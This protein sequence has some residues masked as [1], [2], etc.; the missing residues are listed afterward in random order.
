MKEIYGIYE[1]IRIMDKQKKQAIW[2]ATFAAAFVADV[3]GL[4]R[5]SWQMGKGKARADLAN[6]HDYGCAESAVAIADAAIKGI[7][8]I[9]AEDEEFDWNRTN[10][11]DEA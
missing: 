4:Y 1:R 9:E 10:K 11:P 8:Q 3:D 5:A 6:E 7:E 2:N